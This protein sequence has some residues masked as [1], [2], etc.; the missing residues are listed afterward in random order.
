MVGGGGYEIQ[1]PVTPEVLEKIR[2]AALA[3]DD[4]PMDMAQ[5]LQSQ[6]LD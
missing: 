3:S 1:T 5:I 2:E 4:I 6:L